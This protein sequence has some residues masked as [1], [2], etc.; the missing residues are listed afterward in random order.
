MKDEPL[1]DW[2]PLEQ[3]NQRDQRQLYDEM[4][5]RCP[6]AHSKL[7]GWSLFRHEDIVAVLAD[8]QT[9][10]NVSEF[11]AIPNGMDPPVH[12]KYRKALDGNFKNEQMSRLEPQAR[13]IAVDLL[14]TVRTGDKVEM[15]SAFVNPFTL[16]ALCAL[17]G[18]P[19]KQWVYLDS[20]VQ[21]SLKAAFEQDPVAGKNL[22]DEFSDHVKTNLKARRGS[23][24][25]QGDA[26]SFLLK[27]AVDGVQL[28]DDQIVSVLRNWTAGHGTVAGSLGIVLM[29][30]AEDTELQHQLR[31][32]PTL[33]PR[34][35]E[36]ILRVDGPLVANPRVTTKDVKLQGR[37][38]PK[39]EHITLMWI[40]GDRDP[41]AFAQADE[42]NIKRNNAESLVWGQGIH[43]CQGAPLARLEIRVAV[44]QMLLKT[45]GFALADEVPCRAVYPSNGL[46]SLHLRFS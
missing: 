23:R 2:D 10:S 37:S 24:Y 1:N 12:G 13:K 39:G 35:V 14:E 28:E 42:L 3:V 33:I 30:L 19:E 9:Y 31:R 4:R 43:V 8:P 21:D 34:A 32:D 38:I 36:E 25:D 22:A 20:W 41:D 7:M 45:K 27:T 26:T 11:L 16:K 6:V 40:A 46:T 29:H 15:I 44:E 18:W 5:E 17:L